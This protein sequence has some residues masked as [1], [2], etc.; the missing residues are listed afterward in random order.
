LHANDIAEANVLF[1][2]EAYVDFR[3]NAVYAI[4]HPKL[5]GLKADVT[6]KAGNV[7]GVP[8]QIL[9][10]NSPRDDRRLSVQVV[11]TAGASPLVATHSI[12]ESA[13]N[14]RVYLTPD[15]DPRFSA[16]MTFAAVT[17]GVTRYTTPLMHMF[18]GEISTGGA[19][20]PKRYDSGAFIFG[21]GPRTAVASFTNVN[22]LLHPSMFVD[23]F[24]PRGEARVG[25]RSAT[26][27]VTFGADGKQKATAALYP[28]P[29]DIAAKGKYTL[30]TT[31]NATQ[32][33]D[34]AQ[35]TKLT[36]TLDSSRLD[37]L[38]PTL[39][40]IYL[41]DGAG[42]AARVA[43]SRSAAAIYFSAADYAYSPFKTYQQIRAEATTLSYRYAGATSW[44]VLG[45]TQVGEDPNAGFVYRADLSS[46]TNVDWARVD[47]KIDIEDNAGNTT[48]VVMLPAF[49]VG[50]E[51]PARRRAAP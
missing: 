9:F 10:P 18:D 43:P 21:A 32:Y 41:V 34:I 6:L 37:Y 46:V 45:L 3:G 29:L 7:K 28:A 49:S 13:W 51:Y 19:A 2:D 36:M 22:G 11:A 14:G 30:E 12:A 15:A 31:N 38:P 39:T 16:G 42:N 40:G 33:P 5:D 8:V 44:T 24:G 25:D 50:S 1:F 35:Q 48:S 26:T 47:L 27:V 17:D 4:Q 20:S 23:V